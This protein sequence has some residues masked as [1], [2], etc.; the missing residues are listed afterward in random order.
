MIVLRTYKY[1]IYP[2]KSQI[3]RLESQFSM[4]RHLYNWALYERIKGH[5]LE[6]RSVGYAEQQNNLLK[7][8]KD[9]RPWYKSVQSQVLQ[10]VLHRL[11]KAYQYFFR[12]VKNGETPG[13]PKFKKRGQWESI[14]YPQ[15]KKRPEY[16]ENIGFVVPVSKIGNVKIN[17]HHEIPW[18]TEIKTLQIKKEGDKWFACFC[19]K[20]EI[21]PQPKQDLPPLGIDLGV[22]DLCYTSNGDHCGTPKHY[23]V[24]ED[25][26]IANMTKRPKPKQDENDKYVK[27][28]ACWKSGM[29]KSMADAGWGIFLNILH[30]KGAWQGK[31]VIKVPPQYTSQTCP[32]CGIVVQKSLSTHRAEKTR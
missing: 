16:K 7:R 14:T 15:Q 18:F 24:H 29:N 10:D 12:R 5:E 4:C 22:I 8:I 25:L 31:T 1:R 21:F 9:E 11:D 6:G 19:V 2:T 30:H 26:E 3:T 27:N 23:R 20:E 32:E 17:L 13:F 28:G